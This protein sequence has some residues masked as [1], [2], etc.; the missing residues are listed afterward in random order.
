MNELD[1]ARAE[2]IVELSRSLLE[3]IK[4]N[5]KVHGN[6]PRL[7]SVLAASLTITIKEIDN[8]APGF[9]KHMYMMLEQDV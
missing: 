9:C 7:S 1:M 3:T 8:M 6:D 5:L 4:S 2:T